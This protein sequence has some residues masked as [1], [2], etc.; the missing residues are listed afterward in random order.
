VFREQ[1]KLDTNLD[2]WLEVIWDRTLCLEN[3]WMINS[4]VDSAEVIISDISITNFI[5]LISPQPVDW[6]LQIKLY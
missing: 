1:K 5:Q 4:L 6:F 2:S 3:I